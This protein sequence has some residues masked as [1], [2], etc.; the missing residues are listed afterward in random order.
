M[1][2]TDA[3]LESGKL[4]AQSLAELPQS[5]RRMHLK[6]LAVASYIYICRC[7]YT[8]IHIYVRTYM[9][10]YMEV[11]K[12]IIKQITDC[13]YGSTNESAYTNSK[14]IFEK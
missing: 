5:C 14:S 3:G 12:R 7:I 6:V 9:Y 11:Y 2:S 10:T 1:T 13:V 8:C 4:Q